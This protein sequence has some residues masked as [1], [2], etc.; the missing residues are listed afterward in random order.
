MGKRKFEGISCSR[1]RTPRFPITSCRLDGSKEHGFVYLPGSSS[2]EVPGTGPSQQP[3]AY[4]PPPADPVELD[5]PTTASVSS[6]RYRAEKE[7][8][9][10]KWEELRDRLLETATQMAAPASYL[11]SICSKE[12]S[13]PISCEECGPTVTYCPEC[14]VKCHSTPSHHP[15]QWLEDYYQ[16]EPFEPTT[17]E[18]IILERPDHKDCANRILKPFNVFDSTGRHSFWRVYVCSH[19]EEACTL[20]RFGLWAASADRPQTAFS[21]SLLEWLTAL[22]LECQVSVLGF[23]NA[24][25]WR[26]NLS[27]PEVNLLYKA[28]IGEP[29][30]EFHHY[31][32]RKRTLQH[33]C[34][35]AGSG[36]ECPACP[37]D[38]GNL[39]VSLDANFGLVRKRT[40]GSSSRAP[41]HKDLYFLDDAAVQDFMST[42]SEEVKPDEDCNNFKAGSSVR[43]KGRQE[44]LHVTGVFGAVCRH[45]MPLKFLNMHHGE[46]LGYPVYMIQQL[47]SSVQPGTNVKLLVMYDIACIMTSHLRNAGMDEMLDSVKFAIPIFHCYG[48]KASC[49]VLYSPRRLEGFGLTDGECVERLWSF[50][51]RFSSI[52]KEMTPSHRTDLLTDALLHY[53]RRK[54]SDM[55]MSIMQS[56]DKAVATHNMAENEI[57]TLLN[58]SQVAVTEEDVEMWRQAEIDTITARNKEK[59][60]STVRQWKKA[61]VLNLSAFV[62]LREEIQSCRD[63]SLR[64]ALLARYRELEKKLTDTEGIRGISRW[65]EDSEEYRATILHVDTEERKLVLEKL[66]REASERT[67]LLSLKRKYPGRRRHSTVT[68]KASN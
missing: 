57:A 29:M 33:L 53:A 48:H 11:C 67:F 50:L 49:Q 55:P 44:K 47:L 16:Y 12:E 20:L 7:K 4:L 21:T 26:H 36:T 14:C 40:A 58:Q 62:S 32:H 30:A 27:V 60:S 9:L 43:S 23:C 41:L 61:Y 51:R 5:Q 17:S 2:V 54:V 66:W 24:L 8:E 38:D 39:M 59:P 52:T 19:E 25:R 42:Y 35:Q 28:L 68:E 31:I 13:S 18:N 15:K 3:E 64:T 22:T 6:N 10:A 45:S 34:S 1:P 37:K 63:G 46:R 65:K 56:F